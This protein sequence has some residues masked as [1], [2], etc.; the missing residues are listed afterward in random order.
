MATT[1]PTAHPEVRFPP[2]LIHAT[3]LLAGWLLNS[4]WPLPMTRTV[5]WGREMLALVLLVIWLSLMLGAV[6]TLRHARTTIMPHRPAAALVTS[7]PYRF[8]R[9]PMYVSLAALYLA[10]TLLFNSWWQ[11]VLLPLVVLATQRAVIAR[12]ERYLEGAFPVEYPAYR[13]RVRRWL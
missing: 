7:G 8:T 10:V 2:P 13:E 6:V 3:G 12:E 9:N 4:Q 5:A 1:S 11:V